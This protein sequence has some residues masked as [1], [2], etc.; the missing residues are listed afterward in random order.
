MCVWGGGGGEGGCVCI[1]I[2]SYYL[3]CDLVYG[4]IMYSNFYLLTGMYYM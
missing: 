3:V 1:C 2:N 4:R